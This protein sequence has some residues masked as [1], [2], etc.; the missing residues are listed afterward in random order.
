MM[1]KRTVLTV[2]AAA[3]FALSASAGAQPITV[4]DAGFDDYVLAEGGYID[5]VDASYTGAWKC[6]AGNA[7]I[8]YGYWAS[9]GYTEDLPAHSGNNKVYA[10]ADY[11]YQILDETF[12][13]GETY[14]LSVWVG[15]PWEGYDSGWWLYFT[16]E[17]YNNNLIEA[18]GTAGLSWEQVSLA[19]TATATDAGNKIGIKMWADSEVAFDDVT[20]VPEPATLA[21]LGLGALMLRRKRS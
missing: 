18:S 5:V 12:V 16:G 6:D 19:Y 8:D 20:V 9:E 15:Q 4:L 7:W 21:L 17:D 14:T 1:R 11:L 13:E 10:Y 2:L 3:V